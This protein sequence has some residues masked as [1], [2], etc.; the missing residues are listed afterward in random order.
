MS[1]DEGGAVAISEVSDT[2]Q[3]ECLTPLPTRVSDTG[4]KVLHKETFSDNI[5]GK[6]LLKMAQMV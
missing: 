5:F 6:W 1:A 4:M 2:G 3:Y